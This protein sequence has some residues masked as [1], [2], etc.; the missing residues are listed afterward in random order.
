MEQE[1]TARCKAFSGEG[2]RENRILVERDGS[3]LVWDEVAGHYTRRHALSA[4]QQARLRKRARQ[5]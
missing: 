1:F 5:L 2:A 3:V 4:R